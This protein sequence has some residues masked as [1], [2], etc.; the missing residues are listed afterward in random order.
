M[1]EGMSHLAAADLPCVVVLVQRGGPGAGSTRHAQTDYSS[2]VKG[3][4][5]GDYKNIVLAPASVQEIYDLMQRAFY[6]SDK[7][8]NPVIV[9]SDGILGQ[10][11]EPL[12][13][14]KIG[15]GALPEKDWALRGR[16]NQKD[17]GRRF[18]HSAPGLIGTSQGPD[19]NDWLTHAQKKYED[20]SS[21]VEYEIIHG[22]DAELFIIAYGYPA[23]SAEE[24]VNL[25][26]E[27]DLKVGLIRPITLWPFPSEIIKKK[28]TEGCR[29]L[30]VE[31]SLGQM[32]DDVR[33]SVEGKSDVHLCGILSRHLRHDGGMLM[34]GMIVNEIM[35]LL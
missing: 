30:V 6:L 16:D 4:G 28:A 34:P 21:E 8:C 14:N 13:F 29:F 22:E 9:L 25:A 18:I 24:A 19:Y 26:R 11:R 17:G 27:K 31:D 2:V 5:P 33:F 23:R 12:E 1:Q 32:V 35:N 10:V 15:F 3:G 7:Y 20:M